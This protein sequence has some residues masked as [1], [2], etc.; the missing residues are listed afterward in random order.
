MP[1]DLEDLPDLTNI[2]EN[3]RK[4]EEASGILRYKYLI[5]G[6]GTAAYAAIKTI[7]EN[8]PDAEVSLKLL[9]RLR[10]NRNFRSLL[11]RPTTVL[12][13]NA[14]HFRKNF[15]GMKIQTL[16]KT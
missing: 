1:T 10:S 6:G 16:L 5:V 2:S 8:D 9:P 15:G 14:R 3:Q 4:E 12:L 7:R 11:S 13:T